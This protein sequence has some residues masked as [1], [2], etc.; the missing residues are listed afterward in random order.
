MFDKAGRM[1]GRGA[2]VCGDVNHLVMSGSSASIDTLGRGKL[3]NA[4]RTN[5]D[6]TT[7]KLL[8]EAIATHLIEKQSEQG[9]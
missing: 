9:N 2:Y 3:N 7:V 6:E 4:L 5:L 1:D 8:G